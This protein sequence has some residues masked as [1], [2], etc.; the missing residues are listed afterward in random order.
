MPTCG[1]RRAA[2]VLLCTVT[3]FAAAILVMAARQGL[4]ADRSRGCMVLSF[5]TSGGALLN[6]R[7]G[8]AA[9]GE[10]DQS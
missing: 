8:E 9:D 3:I 7:F 1:N 6:G 5:V 2:L 10:A 4:W